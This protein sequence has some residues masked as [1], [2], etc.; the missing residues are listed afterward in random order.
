MTEVSIEPRSFCGISRNEGVFCQ[1][2]EIHEA[3]VS[4]LR[5]FAY[6]S[7][8]PV[9][10]GEPDVRCEEAFIHQKEPDKNVMV[11]LHWDLHILSGHKGKQNI[12][13][14]FH[15]SI[16]LETPSLSFKVLDPVDAL[17]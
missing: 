4:F 12:K 13:E 10:S 5:F 16:Q 2:L 3:M 17:R 14:L 15:R 6:T 9:G 11:E 7:G 1:Q 8:K